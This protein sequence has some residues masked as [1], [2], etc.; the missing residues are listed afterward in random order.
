MRTLVMAMLFWTTGAMLSACSDDRR[1]SGGDDADDLGVGAQCSDNLDCL[2]GQTCLPFKG[3]YCGLEDC[4]GDVDCP[5]DSACVAHDDGNN[6][7]FRICV[8]K[9]ECNVNRDV[10]LEAN[11]SSNVD[12]VDGKASFKA[13]VPPS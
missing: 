12:F 4:T 1:G 2:E 3:G 13:C 10:D 8:D 11:C 5:D 7:C 9:S 6:Y